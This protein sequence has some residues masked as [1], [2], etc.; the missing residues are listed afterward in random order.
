MFAM[1]TGK[2][3]GL[4]SVLSIPTII[5]VLMTANGSTS[6]MKAYRRYMQT[7]F[8]MFSWYTDELRPGTS[9]WQSLEAVRKRHV[10]VTL[11]SEKMDA[12]I[13]SQKDMALTQFA[14]F[15]FALLRPHLVGLRV[16]P[17]DYEAFVHFWR[18][19]GHMQGIRDEYNLC[20]DSWPATRPRLELVMDEIFRPHLENTDAH[21][22][23]MSGMLLNGFW[24]LNPLLNYGSFLYFVRTLVGCDGYVYSDTDLGMLNVAGGQADAAEAERRVTEVRR[25]IGLVA[26]ANLWVHMQLHGSWMRCGWVRSY[27]NWHLKAAVWCIQHIP[28]LAIAQF[29][30]KRAYVR[31][32]GETKKGEKGEKAQ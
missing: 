7:I 21:F 6:P 29:G 9:S 28:V 24:C 3:V 4:V 27:M 22:T 1:V 18:V 25:S 19:L 31:V 32:L 16:S 17:A 12:G 5:R 8:H 26:R 2:L 20:A 23:R 10:A 11:H 30:R 13:I 15:G 14:F